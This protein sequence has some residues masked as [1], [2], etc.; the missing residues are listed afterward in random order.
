ME[1]LQ[2]KRERQKEYRDNNREVLRE[3]F[4]IYYNENREDINRRRRIVYLEKK[5]AHIPDVSDN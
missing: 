2:K 3:K 1:A 4:R 5:Y